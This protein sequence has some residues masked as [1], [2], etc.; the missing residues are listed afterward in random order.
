MYLEFQNKTRAK[1][2]PYDRLADS[3]LPFLS[4]SL[5]MSVDPKVS[6]QPELKLST[7]SLEADKS[8]EGHCVSKIR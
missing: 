5:S 3:G 6:L 1:F 7:D 8:V 2:S 4:L